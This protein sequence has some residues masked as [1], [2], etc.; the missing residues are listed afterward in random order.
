MHKPSRHISLLPGSA[1][2]L[3]PET[4]LASFSRA[5]LER[6][7]ASLSSTFP[8]KP[9]RLLAPPGPAATGLPGPGHLLATLRA[10]SENGPRLP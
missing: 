9:P 2:A 5:R 10:A 8:A 3:W 6:W 4:W 7:L 1:L